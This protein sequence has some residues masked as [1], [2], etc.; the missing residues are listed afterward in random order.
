MLSKWLTSV[1]ENGVRV[2]TVIEKTELVEGDSLN[3]SVYITTLSDDEEDKI[4]YI[5]LKVLCEQA[6]R[7]LSIV[8]KH[9][10]ELVGSIRSKEAEIV[11]FELIPDERWMCEADERLIFQTTVVFLDGTEIEE[12]G[13]ISYRME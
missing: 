9:S 1:E 12:V 7:E 11:P 13:I 2:E 5:S 8:A 3:G 4:D 6:G 10:F